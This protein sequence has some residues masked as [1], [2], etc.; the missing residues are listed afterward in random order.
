MVFVNFP[1]VVI[2]GRF[3][4]DGRKTYDYFVPNDSIFINDLNTVEWNVAKFDDNEGAAIVNTP[5]EKNATFYVDKILIN[6]KSY[7]HQARKEIESLDLFYI[8]R[9]VLSW[10]DGDTESVE[11][12]KNPGKKLKSK[13]EKI[14][15][16]DPEDIGSWHSDNEE[17]TSYAIDNSGKVSLP[18]NKT[19]PF[20]SPNGNSSIFNNGTINGTIINKTEEKGKNSMKKMF[21]NIKGFDNIGMVEGAFG[22]SLIDNK[23]AVKIG[24]S[25]YSFDKESNTLT[26]ASSFVMEMPVPA[27]VLPVQVKDLKKGDIILH[28]GTYVFI[29]DIQENSNLVVITADGEQ[30]T[31][32]L[33]KNVLMGNLSFVERLTSPFGDML[34]N[35]N[36]NGNGG[37]FGNP[38]VMMMIMGGMGDSSDSK[39]D[40]MMQAMM[41]SQMMG[42]SFAPQSQEEKSDK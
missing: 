22:L 20:I 2:K 25:F 40:G 30:K 7:E 26:D 31:K 33:V 15:M 28:E 32:T 21:K 8:N 41:M 24:D 27:M 18:A 4:H 17:P 19:N 6:P 16:P 39:M 35:G 1:K 23:Q 34:S 9:H 13:Q 11:D 5:Y 10:K 14:H 29:K 36:Q 37:M 12:P 38:M 42:N 3:S